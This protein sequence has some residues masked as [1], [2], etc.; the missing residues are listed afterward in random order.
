MSAAVLLSAL[1]GFLLSLLGGC[2]S[3][4]ELPASRHDVGTPP[5]APASP[6]GRDEGEQA[7]LQQALHRTIE[8]LRKRPGSEPQLAVLLAFQDSLQATGNPDGNTLAA[9]CAPEDPHEVLVTGYY[10]PALEG[11][12][13][14]EGP[15]Q[16]PLYAPP[17]DLRPGE[18]FHTRQA[19]DGEGALKGRG[20]EIAWLADPLEAYLLHVQGSGRLR[21]PDGRAVRVAYAGNNSRPY[22]SIGRVLVEEGQMA[23]EEA[24]LPA[25]RSYLK[26]HPEDRDRLLWQNERYIFF[27][28]TEQDGPTGS[29]GAVLT[30]G[31][32]VAV[33]P[34]VYPLGGLALLETEI[35]VVEGGRVTGW[36]PFKQ[37]VLLQ[38]T[39]AAI[40]GPGRVDLFMGSGPVAEAAAGV[41]RRPGRFSL[42]R[43]NTANDAD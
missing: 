16:Y 28:L 13:R 31:R 23:L 41:L 5:P 15:Y 29:L 20:L 18:P 37:I 38:D 33:D 7:S 6:A 32:S 26:R 42:L 24:T 40:R 21:L 43:V 17:L 27:R 11:S 22:T 19:I 8:A 25:I 4:E 12:L 34:E 1:G 35:P 30:P 9:A 36:R 2:A 10:E 39:G 3:T 14:Q